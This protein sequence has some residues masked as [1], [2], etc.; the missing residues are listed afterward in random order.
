MVE[1]D[2]GVRDDHSVS[3]RDDT[4][5][6]LLVHP[7][8]DDGVLVQLGAEVVP[9]LLPV[10]SVALLLLQESVHL[11][12]EVSVGV[13]VSEV[14]SLHPAHNVI[15]VLPAAGVDLVASHVE[16]VIEEDALSLLVSRPL[17]EHAVDQLPGL[18][19]SG[20]Q[21]L[22]AVDA[23]THLGVSSAPRGLVSGHI[24]LGDHADSAHAGVLHDLL[25]IHGGVSLHGGV[26]TLPPLGERQ[27]LGGI[28]LRVGD[29][30]VKDV[31]LGVGHRVDQLLDGGKG[32]IVAGGIHQNTTVRETGSIDDLPRRVLDNV[33][34]GDRIVDDKLGDGFDSV[35]RSEGV[36]GMDRDVGSV[37]GNGDLVGLVGVHLELRLSLV[38]LHVDVADA[39]LDNGG[40]AVED[41]VHV[42]LERLDQ[43]VRLLRSEEA[44]VLGVDRHRRVSVSVLFRKRPNVRHV[45]AR[46]NDEENCKPSNC[47]HTNKVN[48]EKT[49]KW[50]P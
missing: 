33:G 6:G 11:V 19:G 7:R 38:H 23:R 21:R 27:R 39:R 42:S 47:T 17:A 49:Q 15:S 13:T 36:L 35:H 22:L 24:H 50:I 26:G 20:V 28:G 8:L 3:V 32:L 12:H 40:L 18:V 16:E 29:V 46:S 34:R 1:V 31:Q 45:A 43:L 14:V 44:E 30:P 2:H 48:M 4:L 37:I 41:D 9:D 10:D 25:H 5:H